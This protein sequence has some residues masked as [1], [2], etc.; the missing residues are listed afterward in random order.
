M[1]PGRWVVKAHFHEGDARFPEEHRYKQATPMAIV[2]LAL[3]HVREPDEWTPADVDDVTIVITPV[4]IVLRPELT[5]CS[6]YP[7]WLSES[8][9]IHVINLYIH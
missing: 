8:V 2:A 9:G 5:V 3:A 7:N 6:I 4:A 1:A